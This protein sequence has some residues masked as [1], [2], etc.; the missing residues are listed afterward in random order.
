MN[1]DRFFKNFRTVSYGLGVFSFLIWLVFSFLAPFVN[2]FSNGY[3]VFNTIHTI[4]LIGWV[5]VYTT[6]TISSRRNRNDFKNKVVEFFNN[7]KEGEVKKAL[8]KGCSSC[9]KKAKQN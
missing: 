6:R 9:K 8:R 7:K 2:I 1:R 4:S 5:M 3:T